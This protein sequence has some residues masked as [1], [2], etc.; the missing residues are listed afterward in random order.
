MNLQKFTKKE[1]IEHINILNNKISNLQSK[2]KI[3]EK[4]ESHDQVSQLGQILETSLNEILIFDC[5][6]FKFVFVNESARSNLGYT[7][8][9]FY[10]MTPSDI[11]PELTPE[12]EKKLVEPLL[13]GKQA[14]LK[15]E[16]TL[17]R[18]DGSIYPVYVVL[19]LST[20]NGQKVFVANKIDITE[21]KKALEELRES[22]NKY[23]VLYEDNPSMYF[24]VDD[25]GIVISVNKFG[26]QQLGYKP[27]ELIGK[28][29]I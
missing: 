18:K 28:P 1:L 29:V 5:Q 3:T 22:E 16:T 9:E 14:R 19:Q 10:N 13:S 21:Q 23:K 20:Y 4:P 2:N 25:Q 15:F 26:A 12:S 24:T 8:E 11:N 27:E 7:S 6:T 17:K